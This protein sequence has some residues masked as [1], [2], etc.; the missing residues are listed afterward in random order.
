MLGANK[1]FHDQLGDNVCRVSMI[2]FRLACQCAKEASA[3][4]HNHF[5]LQY[6][7]ECWSDPEAADKFER[8]GKSEDCM[9]FGHK[10]CDDEDSSECVGGVNKNYVYRVVEGEY[11]PSLSFE[12]LIDTRTSRDSFE[13][14][15]HSDCK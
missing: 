7:G 4:G 2:F 6:Y 12:A 10:P 15:S 14:N 13:K 9:G 1:S 5:G 3:K 8:Y 11:V